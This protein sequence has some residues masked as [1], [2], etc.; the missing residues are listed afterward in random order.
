MSTV[1]DTTQQ[2]LD[3][4]L[5]GPSM[6]D[7]LAAVEAWQQRWG[8]SDG[9]DRLSE[10]VDAFA[11]IVDPAYEETDGRLHHEEEAGP[12]LLFSDLPP[13]RLR[14][15]HELVE[16][17]KERAVTRAREVILSELLAAAQAFHHDSQ[18]HPG[19]V[20]RLGRA[21]EDA[22]ADDWQ[23]RGVNRS[24]RAHWREWTD[25]WVSLMAFA[26]HELGVEG[27]EAIAIE[28]AVGEARDRVTREALLAAAFT[29][30]TTEVPAGS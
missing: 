20:G 21:W 7:L 4:A 11:D 16:A 6:E 15:L 3:R 9:D 8:K 19:P 13:S 22:G 27:D 25:G 29:R 2:E 1:V 17:A 18:G 5:F 24:Q 26:I 28:T 30:P 14:V 23:Q 12:W 10:A